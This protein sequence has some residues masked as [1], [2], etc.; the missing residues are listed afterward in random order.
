MEKNRKIF[1]FCVLIFALFFLRASF[2]SALELHYPTINFAGQSFSLNDTSNFGDWFCYFFGLGTDLAIFLAVLAI[3][4]GGIY[5]LISYSRGKYTDEGKDWIKAG[6]LG[7]LIVVCAALGAYTFN[8]NL[9]SCKLGILSSIIPSLPSS[10][11]TSTSA[12]VVNYQEIPIGTLTENLLTRTMDCYGFDPLG[13]PIDGQ[14]MTTDSGQ[15]ITGP[16]YPDHDRADC[17]LQFIDGAQKK[18]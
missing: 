4:F 12:T 17:L 2:V 18:A 14:Q 13:N 15:I 8:P 6:L 16:T 5:Y 9:T 11:T 10:S 7:L 3:A 1:L